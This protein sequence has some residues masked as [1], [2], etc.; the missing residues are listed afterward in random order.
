MKRRG[1]L[2]RTDH[3]KSE[4]LTSQDNMSGHLQSPAS[5]QFLLLKALRDIVS[6]VCVWSEGI[7]SEFL[8]SC[9]T[10]IAGTPQ[11]KGQSTQIAKKQ[12][13]LLADSFGFICPG[14]EISVWDSCL[15]ANTMKVNG[16]LF[17]VLTTLKSYIFKNLNGYIIV[18]EQSW[19]HWITGS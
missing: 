4:A 15:H 18:Q 10:S 8:W 16:I 1:V 12:I 6:E 17:V 7:R 9:L 19:L 13:S 2:W 14:F 11:L 3:F 5:Q